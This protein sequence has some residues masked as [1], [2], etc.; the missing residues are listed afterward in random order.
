MS[1]I[2]EVLWLYL[3]NKAEKSPRPRG[4]CILRVEGD[5]ELASE[6]C[7]LSN[8]LSSMKSDKQGQKREGVKAGAVS[9]GF[10]EKR[11][12]GEISNW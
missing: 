5:N 2:Y 9:G 10:T 12:W 11:N 6:K 8:V 7:D 1:G 3:I 4:T